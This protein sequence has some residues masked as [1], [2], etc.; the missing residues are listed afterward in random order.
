V[1]KRR[2]GA[3]KLG[4]LVQLLILTAIGYFGVP[5]AQ[6]YW[7]FVQYRDAMIQEVRF[8]GG[9]PIPQIRARLMNI[10]DS[11]GL[12]EDAGILLIKKQG[13]VISIE[14]HYEETIDLPGF[15]KEIHFE[16]KASGT[17]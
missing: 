8:R 13:R 14:A 1:V 5:A 9:Q 2:T 17:F 6:K 12:P 4:C 15:K 3:T 11:L 7:L 16:P 10:A